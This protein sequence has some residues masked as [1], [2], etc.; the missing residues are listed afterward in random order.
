[1]PKC[2][3]TVLQLARASELLC[4]NSPRSDPKLLTSVPMFYHDS[5]PPLELSRPTEYS[6]FRGLEKPTLTPK[7]K[8]TCAEPAHI[9]PRLVQKTTLTP[10]VWNI[11]RRRRGSP[12]FPKGVQGKQYHMALGI[13]SQ[14]QNVQ[15][16][17]IHRNIHTAPQRNSTAAMHILDSILHPYMKSF[18]N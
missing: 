3:K 5:E 1:M 8:V 12:H 15:N 10:K 2:F 14:V 18:S 9:A 13:G 6:Y 7:V 11:P 17:Q 16:R 4:P